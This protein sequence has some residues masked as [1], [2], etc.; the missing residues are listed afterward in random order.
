MDY[1]LGTS[2]EEIVENDVSLGLLSKC[3]KQNKL[4]E[5]YQ[6]YYKIIEDANSSQKCREYGISHINNRRKH[7][8]FK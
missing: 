6:I 5:M 3:E 8:R 1:L 2:F 4:N 7:T